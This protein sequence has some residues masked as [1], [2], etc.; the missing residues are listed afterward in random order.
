M[1]PPP[2]EKNICTQQLSRMI[3]SIIQRQFFPAPLP[4]PRRAA[5]QQMSNDKTTATK[6]EREEHTMAANMNM[7]DRRELETEELEKVSGGNWFCDDDY[8]YE[9]SEGG[10]TGGW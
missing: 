7:T 6:T 2:A 5:Y 9:K 4:C 1:N 3:L 10:S 8:Y